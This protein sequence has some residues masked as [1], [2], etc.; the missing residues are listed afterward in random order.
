MFKTLGTATIF[1]LAV[2]AA[3]AAVLDLESGYS[4]DITPI[5]GNE[6]EAGFGVTFFS[7]SGLNIVKVGGPLDG[8]VPNDTPNPADAFGDFFL[9]S[10]FGRTTDLTI[11]Y[12][13]PVAETSFDVGD[14][15]GS[16]TQLEEFT[17]LALDADGNVLASRFV[18]GN[19][20]EAGDAAVT[21]I[22]FSGLSGLI[23]KID[24][25]GS[26]PGGSRL[27]GIAF[28]N[29]NTTIDNTGGTTPVPLPAGL[30][31]A[32]AA[33]GALGLLRVRRKA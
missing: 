18:D 27:I 16:G 15:D 3:Q 30:P 7:T 28:D 17:F 5:I 21:R 13:T 26:T 4:A 24:I 20:P 29:F 25:A 32:A 2:G 11:T 9:T 22:G 23:A 12:T 8:F 19:D 6:F 31:L 10:D 1:A 33:F 14:I